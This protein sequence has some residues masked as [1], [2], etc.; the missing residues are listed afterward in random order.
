FLIHRLRDKYSTTE[1]SCRMWVEGEDQIGE[2]TKDRV[3][4]SDQ[5]VILDRISS[6][7]DLR[8]IFEAT[9]IADIPE[10]ESQFELDS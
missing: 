10:D 5:L 8:G 2:T 4:R 7:P 3:F 9:A 1:F 6:N